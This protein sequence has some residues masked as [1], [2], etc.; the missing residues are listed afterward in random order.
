MRG[1]KRRV[2]PHS[3]RAAGQ[4]KAISPV[5]TRLAARIG[6]H[7]HAISSPSSDEA[8]A[9]PGCAQ[10]AGQPGETG[11]RKEMEIHD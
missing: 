6:G 9:S 2:H 7:G 10:S 8:E 5:G 11:K 1:I 4:L 3:F